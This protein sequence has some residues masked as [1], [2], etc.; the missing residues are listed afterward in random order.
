MYLFF[1][2]ID[3]TIFFFQTDIESS[4]SFMG[5]NEEMK[6]RITELLTTLEKVK[7]N[8]ELRQQQSEEVIQDLK[9]SNE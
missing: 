6:S 4:S 8:S 2:E 5:R 9:K 3:L 1:R 7:R